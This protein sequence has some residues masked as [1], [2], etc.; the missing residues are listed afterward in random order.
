[1]RLLERVVRRLLRGRSR[2][3]MLASQLAAGWLSRSLD[4]AFEKAAIDWHG[5]R[6]CLLLSFDVD[7]PEDALALEPIARALAA[8]GLQGSFACVGRWVEDYPEPHRAL[9]EAGHEVFNHTYSH[10]ELVSS[11][12]HFVSRRA[13]LNPRRWGELAP[14]EQEREVRRC[15]E[16][17]DQRLGYRM[18]GFRVPHFGNAEP[19]GIYPALRA[20]AL[21]Y[22]TSV[23]ASRARDLGLPYAPKGLLEIPVTTCPRHP[24]ASLDSWHAYYARGGWHRQD[25]FEVLQR[26][27]E[28]AVEKRALTNVYLDPKDCERLGFDRLF[29]LV[30]GMKLDCWTPTYAEFTAWWMG[31][32][33]AGVPQAAAGVR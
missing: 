25:F 17:V 33:S 12:G 18:R 6:S 28:R 13:D 7:F 5:R 3:A 2:P 24:L 9:L 20:L 29:D 30:A 4:R 22:S 10:P 8:R 23:L 27:L 32:R 31:A 16:V 11:P 15:Q 1:M 14:E 21:E 26:R 19:E